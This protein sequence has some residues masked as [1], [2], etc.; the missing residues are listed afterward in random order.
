MAIE[1]IVLGLLFFLILSSLVFGLFTGQKI[2]ILGAFVLLMFGGV[3]IQSSGGIIVGHY[4]LDEG[5][6]S[7][8]VVSLSDPVLFLFSQICFWFGLV[9]SAWLGLTAAFGGNKTSSGSPFS[10]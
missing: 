10:W 3:L 7:N 4:Y 9:V 2:F 6:I 8:I 5:G 1:L